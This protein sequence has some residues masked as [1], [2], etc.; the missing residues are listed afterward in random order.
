[1]AISHTHSMQHA[2]NV[3][4]QPA[5]ASL[6]LVGNPY[7]RMSDS[8]L[9][10]E[11]GKNYSAFQPRPSWYATEGKIQ[12][13]AKRTM[14]SGEPQQDKLTMLARELV[15]R[16]HVMEQLD[17]TGHGQRD[18]LI[19]NGN[20]RIAA[21]NLSKCPPPL[22]DPCYSQPCRPQPGRPNPCGS[23]PLNIYRSMSDSSVALAFG[24]NYK[25]FGNPQRNGVADLGQIFKM[26]RREM[27][28]NWAQDNMTLLAREIVN[29]P[30]VSRAL[31]SIDDNGRQDGIIGYRNAQLAAAYLARRG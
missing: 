14:P 30:Y 10:L 4:S 1:M 21:N 17:T 13:M 7:L 27:S 26:A 23:S 16:D 8:D 11:F 28:G 9:A 20:P 12:E 22:P 25:E 29:R 5:Q 18:G 2:Q 15:K 6:R 24:N 31:D 19:G 3:H